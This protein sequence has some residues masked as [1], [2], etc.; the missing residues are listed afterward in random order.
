MGARLTRSNVGTWEKHATV[1]LTKKLKEL[2]GKKQAE[3]QADIAEHLLK[4][5]K[6]NVEA[7][8]IK[9]G[10]NYTYVH[11]NTFLDSI[12]VEINGDKIKIAIDDSRK[13]D[14]ETTVGQVYEWLV[15]GTSTSSEKHYTFKAG[16]GIDDYRMGKPHATPR[17]LFEEHTRV[18][19]K[20]YLESL[21]SKLERNNHRR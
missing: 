10:G 4:T 3:L 15:D 6:D 17:H 2:A 12:G 11:T 14:D 19:M 21:K 1:K 9:S 7:S 18:D 20:A 13:Y 5:Y 16:S 8:Y